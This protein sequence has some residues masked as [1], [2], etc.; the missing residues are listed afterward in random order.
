M[1]IS[2]QPNFFIGALLTLFALFTFLP[3]Y[4]VI[5]ASVS[6]PKLITEGELMLYP[7]GF[8]LSAYAMILENQKF[9]HS[10]MVTITRTTLG[11]AINLIL[12][13]TLA[14]GLSRSYLPGRKFFMLYIILTMMFNGG[15]VPTFLIVKATGLMD[16]IWALVIPAAIS[17]WNVILLRSFFENVPDS[18]EESARIDG[19]ND[20]YIFWK[21]YLPLSLPAIMTI[22]LFIAVHHWNAF[23]DAVIYT[24][25][26]SLQVMQL[27]LRDMVIHMEMSALMGDMS[28][29]KNDVSSLSLRTASIFLASL[30]IILAYPFIQRF[31]IK[32]VMIG[33]V[34]G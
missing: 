31:F 14:Y 4:Y 26:E 32:G 10:F 19:A 33:A 9:L 8:N 16:T 21:I 6:D 7:K 13:L 2:L 11:L 15:I 30:P 29:V 17:T 34:K 22:G 24:N 20:L 28:S 1:R 18:L 12:Q 25:S 3:F 23:M 27:F 5:L